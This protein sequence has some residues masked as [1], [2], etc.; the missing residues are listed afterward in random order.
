[1]VN[2]NYNERI[3]GW[4]I[5]TMNL[6]LYVQIAYEEINKHIAG[7]DSSN[8]WVVFI[9]LF[10]IP[11]SFLPF[12]VYLFRWKIDFNLDTRRKKMRWGK[13]PEKSSRKLVYAAL[14]LS[15]VMLAHHNVPSALIIAQL[16]R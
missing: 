5:F 10:G 6:V 11:M 16:W 8:F 4:I 9:L 12:I 3:Y 1:M 7:G 14:I 15:L 2:F 13:V